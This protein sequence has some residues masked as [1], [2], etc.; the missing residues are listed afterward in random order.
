MIMGNS[1]RPQIRGRVDHTLKRKWDDAVTRLRTTSE[2]LVASI[3]EH[4]VGLPSA[5]QKR[6]AA[7]LS[8]DE[9]VSLADRVRSQQERHAAEMR[10]ARR[11]SVSGESLALARV[12]WRAIA[13]ARPELGSDSPVSMLFG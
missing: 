4:F 12:A 8:N 10:S 6:I 13:A 3:V 5:E 1:E 2:D 11:S 9:L 7:G